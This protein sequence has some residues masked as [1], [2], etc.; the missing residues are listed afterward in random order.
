M[1]L[2]A[3]IQAPDLET[4]I[5][6]LRKKAEL[7]KLH[8]PDEVTLLIANK[9]T[10]NI[11]VLEGCLIKISAYASL[12]QSKITEDLVREVLKDIL[13]FEDDKHITI[14]II[15][16]V[17]VEFFNL[18]PSDMTAKKRTKSIAFPR[19]IAMYLTREL[20]E[21]SL[22]EIGQNFGGRD[23]TTVM[24]AHELVKNKREADTDFENEMQKI[25]QIINSKSCV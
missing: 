18:K 5:A 2:I 23:H 3:D 21:A 12:T 6:I 24:H 22:P 16:K 17:V 19:Q 4:R 15:K 13:G 1:G 10:S 11:R 14:D 7:E 20:T 25:L 8:L 9:I